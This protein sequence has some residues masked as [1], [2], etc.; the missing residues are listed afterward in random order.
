VDCQ[1]KLSHL[2]VAM[3]VT[4]PDS[5]VLPQARHGQKTRVWRDAVSSGHR[6]RLPH[7]AP[8]AQCFIQTNARCHRPLSEEARAKNWTKSQVRAKVEQAFVVSKRLCGWA[9][10]RS[11]GLAKH[12]HWLY[13]SCGLGVILKF[14]ELG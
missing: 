6:D 8:H 4:V 9:N 11:R 5:Q 7:H 3:T 10:V 12:T 14:V 1:T 13:I 2:I